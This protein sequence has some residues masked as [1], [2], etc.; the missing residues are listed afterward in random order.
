M[1]EPKGIRENTLRVYFHLLKH[2]PCELSDA[3][4]KTRLSTASLA[5]YHLGKVVEAG[6]AR[7]DE[8]GRY[9]AKAESSGQIIRGYSKI[10]TAIVPQLFFFA[11]L[12][13]I[14]TVFFSFESFSNN[15]FLPFVVA[16]SSAMVGVFWFETA[17]LWRRLVV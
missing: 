7:Q 14:L 6:Y 3:R 13:S 8:Q 2:G 11:L 16:M 9:L 5:S 1:E 10:G 12:F 17:R 15:E 4:R